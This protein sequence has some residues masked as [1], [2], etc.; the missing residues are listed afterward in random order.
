MQFRRESDNDARRSERRVGGS[1]A[2]SDR[3]GWM[4]S[5]EPDHFQYQQLAARPDRRA[6]QSP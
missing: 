5:T 2:G 1:T 3:L 4:C 6:S